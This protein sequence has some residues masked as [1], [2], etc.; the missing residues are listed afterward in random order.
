MLTP[1]ETGELFNMIRSLTA[2]GFTVLFISHKL[3]EVKGDLQPRD[4]AAPRAHLR[5]LQHRRLLRQRPGPPDGG[6]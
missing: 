2:K 5:H 4:R 3:N 1:Q 6:P